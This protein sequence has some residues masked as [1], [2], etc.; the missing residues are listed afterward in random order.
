MITTYTKKRKQR[1]RKKNTKIRQEM[2]RGYKVKTVSLRVVLYN[3][4][5]HLLLFTI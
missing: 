3:N 2:E 5:L 4:R 1:G